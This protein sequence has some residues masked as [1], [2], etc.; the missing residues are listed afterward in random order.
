MSPKTHHL[1]WI[2]LRA[3]V[4][5]SSHSYRTDRKLLSLSPASENLGFLPFA[6]LGPL[7]HGESLRGPAVSGCA[8]PLAPWKYKQSKPAELPL[9][10]LERTGDLT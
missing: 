3:P 5:S 2:P 7:R 8:S 1:W 9:T 6:P 4:H 10:N